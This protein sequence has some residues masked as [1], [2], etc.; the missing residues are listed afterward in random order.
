MYLAR[1]DTMEEAVEICRFDPEYSDPELTDGLCA[2]YGEWLMR[3]IAFALGMPRNE[4]GD[5]VI[6][7]PPEKRA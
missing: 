1:Q 7:E 5:I 6:A 2:I 4:L 3:S